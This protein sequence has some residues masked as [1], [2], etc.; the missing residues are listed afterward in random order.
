MPAMHSQLPPARR[1]NPESRVVGYGLVALVTLA[2]VVGIVAVASGDLS[3]FDCN[4]LLTLGALAFFNLTGLE[5]AYVVRR[6]D[7]AAPLGGL[8]LIV[9][10]VSLALALVAIW[11]P[12]D[13]EGGD[14]ALWRAMLIGIAWS[15]AL[16]HVSLLMGRRQ[17]QDRVATKALVATAMGFTVGVASLLTF[18]I[19]RS[20]V[21]PGESFWKMVAATAI[22][23]V[24]STVLGP[25][26]RRL[27][28]DR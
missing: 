28:R 26:V 12:M 22:V 8:T 3:D 16:G 7:A 5:G 11:Q 17:A 20:D 14:D 1:A 13:F 24:A 6:D 27:G 25:L 2:A 10:A 15:V 21:E 18:A 9:S 23:A 19:A 4:V